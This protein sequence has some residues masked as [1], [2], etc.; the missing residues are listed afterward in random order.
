M[1]LDRIKEKLSNLAKD[2]A[3]LSRWMQ[4]LKNNPQ[5][6]KAVAKWASDKKD[7]KNI[8]AQFHN[9]LNSVKKAAQFPHPKAKAPEQPQERVLSRFERR[10]LMQEARE[11]E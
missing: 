3:M 1:N 8:I 5:S 4:K 11:S 7:K 10:R 9:T 6:V 2:D